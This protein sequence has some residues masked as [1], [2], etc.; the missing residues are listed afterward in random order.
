MIWGGISAGLSGGGLLPGLAGYA[1]GKQEEA[2]T[3]KA[4]EWSA[5][6]AQKNRAFQ[7]RMSS[8]AVTRATADMRAAGLNPILAAGAGAATPGGATGSTY[9]ADSSVSQKAASSALDSFRV[10]KEMEA[11]NK[12]IEAQQA[13][14]D[15]SH[16]Q[17]FK[18]VAERRLT[19]QLVKKAEA[20]LP[21]ASAEAEAR[22]RQALIDQKMTTFDAGLKRVG[23]TAEAVGNVIGLPA[24]VI[25]GI[26]NSGK[27]MQRHQN[28][29]QINPR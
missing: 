14:I 5:K 18:V 21:A 12:A 9:Q 2:T 7:E 19:D 22:R 15:L 3:A 13:Q 16:D 25:Q 26:T 23:K 17:A 1:A 20:E 11:T 27:T 29:P 28:R 6:E 4:N 8:S 24:K 10:K